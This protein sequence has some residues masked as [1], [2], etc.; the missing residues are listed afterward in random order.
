MLS[1]KK[2]IVPALLCAILAIPA[3]QAK[4]K[5]KAATNSALDAYVRYRHPHAEKAAE[6]K[7]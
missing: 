7:K 6:A 4:K 1:I 5:P 2:R 3:V